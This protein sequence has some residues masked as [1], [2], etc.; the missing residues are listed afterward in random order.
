MIFIWLYTLACTIP[1]I[2]NWGQASIYTAQLRLLC[3]FV[4]H[5]SVHCTLCTV[6]CS[7]VLSETFV[8]ISLAAPPSDL[9]P[10]G[11][12]CATPAPPCQCAT[13]R[14]YVVFL[15][16]PCHPSPLPPAPPSDLPPFGPSL[17]FFICFCFILLYLVYI[18]VFATMLQ[19]SKLHFRGT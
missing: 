5:C 19:M 4:V 12:L 11:T 7:H 17:L 14:G 10:F 13:F 15:P 1:P 8:Q 9:P 16:M 6:H 18:I 2:F 3:T